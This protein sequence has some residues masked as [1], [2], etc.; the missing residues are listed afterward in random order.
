MTHLVTDSAVC[1]PARIAL[2]SALSPLRLDCLTNSSVLPA[3]TETWHGRFRDS[4]CRVGLV[5]QT[6]L[7]KPTRN[8]GLEGNRRLIHE[9]GSSDGLEVEGKM[10]PRVWRG[11]LRAPTAHASPPEGCSKLSTTTTTPATSPST[12]L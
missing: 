11:T 5:G 2:A 8:I 3:G 4:G 10:P 6:D 7:D 1:V 12:R 9:W